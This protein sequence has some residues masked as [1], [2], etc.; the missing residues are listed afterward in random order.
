[1]EW[2]GRWRKG[3]LFAG[4]WLTAVNH[5]LPQLGVLIQPLVSMKYLGIIW[6]HPLQSVAAP[7]QQHN[8]LRW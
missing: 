5:L 2:D 4:Q 8:V 3:Q 6:N 7:S 1:M